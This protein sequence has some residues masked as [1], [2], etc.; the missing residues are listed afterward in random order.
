MSKD[1]NVSLSIKGTR[2]A[3]NDVQ[4]A[5]FARSLMDGSFGV[6]AGHRNPGELRERFADYSFDRCGVIS[7]NGVEISEF[8]R[9]VDVIASENA[10]YEREE[11]DLRRANK[12][13]SDENA[14]LSARLDG[15]NNACI[16]WEQRHTNVTAKLAAK[17]ALLNAVG[18]DVEVLREKIADQAR[19]L[20]N[21]A[22][23]IAEYQ[24]GKDPVNDWFAKQLQGKIDALTADNQSK[25]NA[26]ASLN[27]DNT[28]MANAIAGHNQRLASFDAEATRMREELAAERAARRNEAAAAAEQIAGIEAKHADNARTYLNEVLSLR[29]ETTR[30]RAS[31][32]TPVI[33]DAVTRDLLNAEIMG[34]HTTIHGLEVQLTAANHNFN[35]ADGAL[36]ARNKELTAATD[37]I[38][39]LKADLNVV[40][41]HYT[42]AM[43]ELNHE[44]GKPG[45][46]PTRV[47]ITVNAD[48]SVHLDTGDSPVVVQGNVSVN[49][50]VAA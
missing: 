46:R 8:L 21:Q 38:N 14:R 22:K 33:M 29:D 49:G 41:R 47:A 23:S 16:V 2:R 34:L 1:I 11:A 18:K 31:L 26:I 36:S 6:K 37:I 48:G 4:F 43:D 45:R 7:V 50:E 35:L 12:E 27:V 20:E 42:D 44:R 3:L 25:S 24:A 9:D 28:K 32:L 39:E 10:Q 13:F 30:F 19:R 5:A 40:H 15:A 17:D